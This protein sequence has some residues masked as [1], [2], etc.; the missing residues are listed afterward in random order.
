VQTN[1]VVRSRY[2]YWVS[3]GVTRLRNGPLALFRVP[4]EREWEQTRSQSQTGDQVTGMAS[5]YRTIVR[6]AQKAIRTMRTIFL[7]GSE[8][9]GVTM[10]R[11]IEFYIPKNFHKPMKWA[12][13]I[14]RGKIIEFYRQ[15]RKS[16]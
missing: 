2:H 10:A 13:A 7:P 5:I 4:W 11:I 8:S 12:A 16:A 9:E 15:T 6:I 1:T 3:R 14:E